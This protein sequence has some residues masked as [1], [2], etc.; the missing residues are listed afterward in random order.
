[1][2]KGAAVSRNPRTRSE[3]GVYHVVARGVGRQLL[4]ESNWEREALLDSIERCV[5]TY[6]V[7]IY[8]WCLMGNHIHI[9]MREGNEPLGTT[10]KMILTGFSMRHNLV[11]GH[12]GHVFQGRFESEP[13]DSDEYLLSAVRYVH[14]NPVKAG[15]GNLSEY[16]WSSYGEYTGNQRLCDTSLVL[17]LLGGIQQFE[18]F[19]AAM[20][21]DQCLDV[22]QTRRR[23]TD[24]EARE[25]ANR[26]L[27][28][29]L[30]SVSSLPRTER[31]AALA[32]LKRIGISI[33]QAERLTGIGRKIVATAFASADDGR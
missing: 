30:G 28:G 6:G 10:M 9:V 5:E 11:T 16:P 31:N 12:V 1:M 17:E 23:M 13:I 22:R 26:V 7:T 33:R 32:E 2:R 8:A 21:S 14:N 4:F 15:I 29:K 19:S 3:S 25:E 18:E 24:E 20:N 27:D